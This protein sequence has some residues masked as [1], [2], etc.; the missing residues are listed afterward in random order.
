MHYVGKVP[1]LAT[2]KPRRAVILPGSQNARRAVMKQSRE[3][4]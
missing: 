1:L 4:L 2:E 3:G